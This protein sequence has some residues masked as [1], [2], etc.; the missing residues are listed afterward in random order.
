MRDVKS[1]IHKAQIDKINF[2]IFYL[3]VMK[4]TSKNVKSSWLVD[5]QKQR[6]N[7]IIKLAITIIFQMWMNSKDIF[8]WVLMYFVTSR[9]APWERQNDLVS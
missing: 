4:Q 6:K 1:K 9:S 3:K 7:L 8:S 5:K 2:S